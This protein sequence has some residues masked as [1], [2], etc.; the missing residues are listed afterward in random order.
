MPN[1][2]DAV[3]F[4]E[5][6]EPVAESSVFASP[7]AESVD[8][9]EIGGEGW[10]GADIEEAYLKA[11]HAMEDIPA[12]DEAT[13][14]ESDSTRSEVAAADGS[15]VADAVP[16]VDLPASDLSASEAAP[17]EPAPGVQP[18]AQAVET[19]ATSKP[20]AGMRLARGTERDQ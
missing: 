12:E 20:A 1:M 11:L 7:V 15:P 16:T 17:S 3:E 4:P 6:S 14:A 19:Q 8:E 9:P 2:N 18:V 10:S 13:A 5:Q